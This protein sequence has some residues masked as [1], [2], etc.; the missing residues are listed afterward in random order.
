METVLGWTQCIGSSVN[1]FPD[2]EL[3]V[4]GPEIEAESAGKALRHRLSPAPGGSASVVLIY[5]DKYQTICCVFGCWLLLSLDFSKW[6]VSS[7]TLCVRCKCRSRI[8]SFPD[9]GDSSVAVVLCFACSQ[10]IIRNGQAANCDQH[11]KPDDEGKAMK[12][13]AGH[14]CGRIVIRLKVI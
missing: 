7:R 1:P 4:V 13:L 6:W 12:Q 14:K 9:E 5:S 11:K 3:S 2:C 8:I 10:D